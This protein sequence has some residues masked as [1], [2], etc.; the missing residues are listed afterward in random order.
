MADVNKTV[1][2]TILGDDKKFA[3][4]MK[5]VGAV[6]KK[7]AIGAT[8]AFAT[9]TVAVVKSVNTFRDFEKQFT[10]VVTLL[11]QSNFATKSLNVGINDLN[12]GVT[13]LRAETGES[14]T[15]LNKGLFDLISAGVDAEKGIDTLRIATNLAKAGAT[16]TSVA[17]DGL[18]SVINAYGYEASDATQLSAKFFTAQKLGKTTIEELSS[19]F[20]KVGTNAESLGV[21]F[22]EVLASISAVTLGGVGTSEAYT[23]LA[24]V[25]ANVIRPTKEASDEAKRLG[26]EFSSTALRAQGLNKFL[27][28]ITESAGFSSTSLETLFG[29]VQASSVAMTLGGNQADKFKDI[30]VELN[31]EVKIAATLQTALDKV[32]KT[33][34]DKWVSLGGRVE[35]LF[36]KLGEKLAPV[37][38]KV[39]DAMDTFIGSMDDEVVASLSKVVKETVS[40]FSDLIKVLKPLAPLVD[41]LAIPFNVL[42]LALDSIRLTLAQIVSLSGKALL[43]LSKMGITGGEEMG[44]AL[45]AVGN[46]QSRKAFKGQ[47]ESLSNLGSNAM[48]ALGMGG[49]QSLP[50]E[51]GEG[52]FFATKPEPK[53]KPKPKPN[54]G[55]DSGGGS[56][57]GNS[58]EGS[59]TDTDYLATISQE[60]P[61]HLR[62]E[63]QQAAFLASLAGQKESELEVMDKHNLDLIR[64]DQKLKQ[65]L[66]DNL[67]GWLVSKFA[68]EE[69]S[70]KNL[71]KLQGD[72]DNAMV[73]L[74]GS[75]NKKLA[76]IGKAY[77][78]AKTIWSTYEAAS[79]AMRTLPFPL[80]IAAA[81][82][83]TAAGLANVSKIKGTSVQGAAGGTMVGGFD[84][85]VDTKMMAVRSGEMILPPDIAV[86]AA[87]TIRDIVRR[88]DEGETSTGSSSGTIVVEFAGDA[89]RLLQQQTKEGTQAGLIA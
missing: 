5:G 53:P 23:G 54:N 8:A 52:D 81:G 82:V 28:S 27:S 24:A 20:G 85:G 34:D 45:I 12:K 74:A 77:S 2:I 48:G 65:G 66:E 3:K 22:E 38:I 76:A 16:N 67:S 72:L 30:L 68:K 14:F 19:S 9:L 41:L 44:K 84:T 29:S 62:T 25:F 32:L 86:K 10:S 73:T 79:N 57:G 70:G 80:S 4:T 42:G 61:N 60:L 50:S 51:G 64:S 58:G 21:S 18:T 15:N 31:D 87:P 83:I 71:V 37:L 75:S 46:A 36:K 56:G 17:V 47:Q 78:I 11:D 88:E 6:A 49:G 69:A 43:G 39:M 55:G 89:A 63:E 33:L 7:V 59:S 40:N 1:K 26:I 35:V 13:K